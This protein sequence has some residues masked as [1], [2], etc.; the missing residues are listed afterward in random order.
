MS[1]FAPGALVVGLGMGL[2]VADAAVAQSLAAIARREQAR[3]DLVERPS[4]V[5]TND[6]LRPYPKAEEVEEPTS[7]GTVD[8]EEAAPEEVAPEAAASTRPGSSRTDPEPPAT[9]RDE[10]Y[11]RGR[12]DAARAQ[13]ERN[14]LFHQ[15]L[16]TRINALTTDFVNTDDPAQRA[17]VAVDRQRALEELERVAEELDRLREDIG[18]IEEEARRAGVPPGWLR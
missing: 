2:L 3:R 8:A 7:D 4:K 1:R 15:A 10:A 18:D 13:L 11:W 16:Q 12:V 5:Y 6:D 17:V 14:E 9:D